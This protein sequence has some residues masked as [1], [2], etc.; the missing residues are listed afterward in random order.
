MWLLLTCIICIIAI[1]FGSV[2][3]YRRYAKTSTMAKILIPIGTPLVIIAFVIVLMFTVL[4]VHS[5]RLESR[6]DVSPLVQVTEMQMELLEEVVMQLTY[7]PMLRDAGWPR[8]TVFEW[9]VENSSVSS[10]RIDVRIHDDETSAIAEMRRTRTFLEQFNDSY[11]E[12][13]NDNNTEAVLEHCMPNNSFPSSSRYFRSHVRI[14]NVVIL[15]YEVRPRYN[16]ANSY[17]SQFIALV[18]DLL[19]EAQLAQDYE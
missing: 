13:V 19:K 7:H 10:L 15:F 2:K 3:L 12:I 18:V 16:L 14:G 8:P 17:S 1:I 6:V 4:N 11:R 9:N 5:M